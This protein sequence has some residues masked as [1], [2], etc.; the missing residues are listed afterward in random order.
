MSDDGEMVA[1]QR[2]LER[3]WA[4]YGTEVLLRSL[5]STLE[6]GTAV[7]EQSRKHPAMIEVRDRLTA[8]LRSVARVMS[9][10]LW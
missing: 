1:C 7:I 9:R 10:V 4:K 8:S 5:A 6:E 3:L 2:E